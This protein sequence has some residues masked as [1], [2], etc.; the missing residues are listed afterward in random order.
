MSFNSPW[1]CLRRV[2]A[3]TRP[4][5]WINE[6]DI[7]VAQTR[8]TLRQT[9]LTCETTAGNPSGHVMFTASILF[10]VIQTILK[11]PSQRSN[12][13]IQYFAWNIYVA[14]LMSISMARMFFA[15][16]FF[17]QCLLGAGFGI[18]IGRM[19]QHRKINDA[20][21]NFGR[22]KA[23]AVATAILSLTISIYFAHYLFGKD[24]QWSIQKVY[25]TLNI[26]YDFNSVIFL[27]QAFN[28]CKDP[29]FIKPETTPI[30]ALVREFGLMFGLVL[31]SPHAKR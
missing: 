13:A 21:M 3:G 19:L 17:H 12:K 5:W 2:L 30:Y 25:S 26:K 11:R 9:Y 28:W 1:N 15:C 4:Y 7:Y 23:I 22:L 20:I 10:F 24:P 16:H 29:Y 27:M 14:I 18:T 8:P 31:C 6:T